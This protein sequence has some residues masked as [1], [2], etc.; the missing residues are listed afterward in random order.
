MW[1]IAVNVRLLDDFEA[2]DWPAVV[3]EGKHLW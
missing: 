1:R 3:I 2:A